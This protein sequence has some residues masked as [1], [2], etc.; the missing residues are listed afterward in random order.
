M[1]PPVEFKSH[2]P[3]IARGYAFDATRPIFHRQKTL[4]KS[5]FIASLLFDPQLQLMKNKLIVLVLALTTAISSAQNS[6]RDPRPRVIFSQPT[7]SRPAPPAAQALEENITLHLQGNFQGF[8]PLNLE[9]TGNGSV[10]TID[11]IVKPEKEGEQPTIVTFQ[12]TIALNP[13]GSYSAAYHLGARVALV[14]GTA[15]RP[16]APFSRNVEYRDLSLKGTAKITEGKPLTISK[17][18]G[19]SLTL[20]ISKAGKAE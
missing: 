8:V 15:A 16:D 10:F 7:P 20:T 13:D 11:L 12:T 17:L 9:L 2:P 19:E 1:P 3:T 6:T 14:T 18:N 5:F 4:P